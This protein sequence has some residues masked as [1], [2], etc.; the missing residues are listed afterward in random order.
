MSNSPTPNLLEKQAP[1]NLS[2]L[3]GVA[4]TTDGVSNGISVQPDSS[5]SPDGQPVSSSVAL[6]AAGLANGVSAMALSAAGLAVD[7][8][9]LPD[10]IP[11]SS[12]GDP[13]ISPD[14]MRASSDMSVDASVLDED[15]GDEGADDDD[16]DLDDGADCPDYVILKARAKALK[17]PVN[18]L[19]VLPA[20]NDPF[21]I[22]PQRR[23]DA[24]WFH[25]FWIDLRLTPGAHIRRVHYRLVSVDG[26]TMA[27]GRPYENTE[28]CWHYICN[29]GRDARYRGLVPAEFIVDHRN[30]DPLIFYTIAPLIKVSERGNWRLARKGWRLY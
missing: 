2:G 30:P 17:R 26:M 4:L 20:S 7:A 8:S 15:G 5:G 22:F 12:D 21:Y 28:L 25:R 19:F 3:S 27:D 11:A 9:V 6:R 10:A 24:E 1:D 18:S 29:S 23:K 14:G 16:S 13:E